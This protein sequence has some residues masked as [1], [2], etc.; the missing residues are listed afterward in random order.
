M[1]AASRRR[2]LSMLQARRAEIADQWYEAIARTSFTPRPATDVRAALNALADRAI[3]VLLDEDF[4]PQQ[5][6]SI[7]AALADLHFIHPDALERTLEVLAAQLPAALSPRQRGALRPRLGALLGAVAA[8]YFAQSRAMILEE[9]DQILRALLVARRQ[10]DEA[11]QAR[12]VAEATVRGRND[13]LS[14]AAHDLRTPLTSI[15]GQADLMRAH[16]S[17]ASLPPADWLRARVES[18]RSGALR[19]AVM[20]EELLD[21][22]RL[23]MGHALELQMETVDVGAVVREVAQAWQERAERDSVRLFVDAPAGLVV[24]ADRIRLQRVVENIVGNAIKYS[25]LSTPVQ[26]TVRRQDDTV[27]IT[28][29]DQGVGIPAEE[30]PLLFTP[31]YRASTS[32]GTPG[33]GLGLAG[34]KTIVNQHGGQITIESSVGV[35]TMVAVTLPMAAPESE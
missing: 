7:G 29:Q 31:F 10:A 28:V 21:V 16:L 22:A 33:I 20:V 1:N 24:P 15:L 35:G 25:P 11:E 12:A 5:A 8:G 26:V 32:Q 9:Q 6:R 17:H 27:A 2:L 18:V 30:L 23:Q 4:V 34:A 3:T 19:M 14:A 13:A